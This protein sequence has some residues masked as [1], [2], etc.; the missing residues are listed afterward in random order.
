MAAEAERASPG[1]RWAVFNRLGDAYLKTG[2]RSRSLKY[3]GKAIDSLLEDDQPEPARA[4]V[5]KVIRLHPGAI[6]THCTLTWL[7]LASMKLP[8]A[9]LSLASYAKAAEKGKQNQLACAQVLEMARLVPEAD[10]LEEAAK[11]L[12]FMGCTADSAKVKTWAAEGTPEGG[13]KDKKSLH[14]LCLKAAIGSNLKLKDK[15]ALT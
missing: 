7:D 15:G 6:R 9:K 5:K 8:E 10:F 14:F 1:A 12:E 3:F 13:L 2:D 11:A 4:V